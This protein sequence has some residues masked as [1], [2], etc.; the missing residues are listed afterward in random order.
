MG[1]EWRGTNRYY[2]RARKVNGRTVKEYVGTGE[3]AHLCAQMDVLESQRAELDRLEKQ[4]A[5]ADFTEGLAG[6]EAV[7]S[8]LCRQSGA[9]VAAA[10]T[11]AGYH[12]HKRGEWRKKRMAKNNTTLAAVDPA[13]DGYIPTD[14]AERR[15]LVTNA[16]YPDKA[17]AAEEARALACLR[18]YPNEQGR[19]TGDSVSA[20]LEL[21]SY[22][23]VH[24]A[25]MVQETEEK[26]RELAGP[27]PSP[28]ESLLIE[29]ILACWLSVAFYEHQA[30]LITKL[31]DGITPQKSAVLQG[32]ID[33]TQRRY[34]EAIKTLAQVRRLQIPINVQVNVAAAGGQQVNLSGSLAVGQP[35]T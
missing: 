22:S 15:K 7:V 12:Q 16:A 2:Y 3:I 24:K 10:L 5:W 30:A 35:N 27:N 6:V 33:T 1:W 13:A 31:Q 4:W 20:V 34:L 25:I 23:P 11:A 29:R 14:R 8:G 19:R 26:R 32:R 21:V 9:I 17:T 18:A 28:L